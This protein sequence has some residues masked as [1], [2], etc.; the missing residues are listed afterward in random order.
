MLSIRFLFISIL[1][2]AT[3][4]FAAPIKL[5][6]LLTSTKPLKP[7]KE[8]DVPTTKYPYPDKTREVNE[9]V[10]KDWQRLTA[11]QQATAEQ[12]DKKMKAEN[13]GAK[14]T[15]GKPG[16]MTAGKPGK[17]EQAKETGKASETPPK[18]ETTV[19]TK[20]K[21]TPVLN[22]LES[23][24]DGIKDPLLQPNEREPLGALPKPPSEWNI[25]NLPDV[26][27]DSSRVDDTFI[28]KLPE[29]GAILM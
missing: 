26:F 17:K 25:N 28:N 21:I 11:K 16:K 5:G 14:R 2:S 19:V 18:L 8:A 6:K 27:G 12:A 13:A 23:K 10:A 15:A 9:E 7:T 29:H 4:S 24:S 20:T 22:D 3:I 1:V